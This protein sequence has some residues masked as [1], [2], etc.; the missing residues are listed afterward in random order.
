MF[1]AKLE[2]IISYSFRGFVMDNQPFII[3]LMLMKNSSKFELTVSE[4][5]KCIKNLHSFLVLYSLL[6]NRIN[7]IL[8][9]LK[10]N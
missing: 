1:V 9:N 3:F 10:L 7:I 2:F 6:T 5:H 8:H 4:A